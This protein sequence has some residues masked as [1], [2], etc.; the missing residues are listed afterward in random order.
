MKD[1]EKNVGLRGSENGKEAGSAVPAEE[2]V[3]ASG[4]GV[5]PPQL[6]SGGATRVADVAAGGHVR[7]ARQSGADSA[8]GAGTE[9]KKDSGVTFFAPKS[10][11]HEEAAGRT[12]RPGTAGTAAKE[13]DEALS[14]KDKL[15]SSL[16]PEAQGPVCG[17]HFLAPGTPA[18]SEQSAKTDSG[19]QILQSEAR[20]FAAGMSP[21][22]EGTVRRA[23][24]SSEAGTMAAE[25]S[26]KTPA[27]SGEV[28]ASRSSGISS[29]VPHEAADETARCARLSPDAAMLADAGTERTPRPGS[30]NIAARN[31]GQKDS[32]VLLKQDGVRSFALNGSSDPEGTIRRTWKSPD[33]GEQARA[34]SQN[35]H[36]QQSV[37]EV[38]TN[39]AK[40]GFGA[41]PAEFGARAFPPGTAAD[42]G[43]FRRNDPDPSETPGKTRPDMPQEPCMCSFSL[44]NADPEATVRR[45]FSG[46]EP[47]RDTNEDPEGTL[48]RRH[49]S[50]GDAGQNAN[51]G[52]E[53]AQA[54]SRFFPCRIQ[55]H[56]EQLEVV[57]CLGRGGEGELYL[58]R[59]GDTLYAAKILQQDSD[60]EILSA[61]SEAQERLRKHH[62]VPC[63]HVG[64]MRDIPGTAL[65]S[66][67]YVIH[68]FYA[69]GDL[70][71]L[72]NLRK[73]NP[74]IRYSGEKPFRPVSECYVSVS[75]DYAQ[76]NEEEFARLVS[77]MA[78]SLKALHEESFAAGTAGAV[79]RDI[80]PQN[81]FVGSDG[82]YALG[83]FGLISAMNTGLSMKFTQRI[84]LSHGYSPPEAYS[85]SAFK[86]TV[87]RKYDYFSLGMTLLHI[88]GGRPRYIIDDAL[89]R[90]DSR[91]VTL[92]DFYETI[93]LSAV[94]VPEELPRRIQNLIRGLL[95]ADPED[96]WG[97]REVSLWLAGENPVV[98]M[99]DR[100]S[101]PE[102][103]L[104]VDGKKESGAQN[105]AAAMV[106]DW[107][108]FSNL[109]SRG[110]LR[111]DWDSPD[112]TYQA[113]V[114]QA[115]EEAR[116][117]DPDI[118][119]QTLILTVD[120][121]IGHVFRGKRYESDEALGTAMLKGALTEEPTESEEYFNE[122][123]TKGALSNS[124][125]IAGGRRD[126]KVFRSIVQLEEAAKERPLAAM[127]AAGSI[128]AKKRIPPVQV[129]AGHK[130]LTFTEAADITRW[131]REELQSCADAYSERNIL[132]VKPPMIPG[133]WMCAQG[134]CLRQ[135]DGSILIDSAE[136]LEPFPVSGPLLGL[137]QFALHPDRDIP[138]LRMNERF[139]AM[140]CRG[141]YV[142]RF[143]SSPEEKAEKRSGFMPANL[144]NFLALFPDV[145]KNHG[146]DDVFL[147]ILKAHTDRLEYISGVRFP[148][149]VRR[150]VSDIDA[151]AGRIRDAANQF[152]RTRAFPD[153][154]ACIFASN[155]VR[156]TLV[157]LRT[158]NYAAAEKVL[159]LAP[160][161]M[162][163]SDPDF[164]DSFSRI[165]DEHT[166]FR[167]TLRELFSLSSQLAQFEEKMQR[168]AASDLSP[169]LLSDTMLFIRNYNQ[170]AKQPLELHLP[171]TTN[172]AE[173]FRQLQTQVQKIRTKLV[174][175][176]KTDEDGN[177]IQAG[178]T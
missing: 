52:T 170:S 124:W 149:T 49:E 83:D 134:E 167:G 112:I 154:A 162:S 69:K 133:K 45:T 99:K 136:I 89:A 3:R 9:E 105:V 25:E 48:R 169:Y 150:S 75:C 21:D 72:E 146:F 101:H 131:V 107:D 111:F 91:A 88:A 54:G 129:K 100:E 110:K 163:V 77:Q 56:M 12:G 96:R 61:M 59:S 33:A 29:C 128:L 44:E 97:E 15:R 35:L 84:G 94:S 109:L 65:D 8:L 74:S 34:G 87:T 14:P 139:F 43:T 153:F 37:Q 123:L 176:G 178:R 26:G 78:K 31:A 104:L 159:E 1:A 7:E 103:S 98:P 165:L 81:I 23:W 22:P 92:S 53:H 117:A 20:S 38:T 115:L 158:A 46:C 13:S 58:C 39:A 135:I 18:G 68:P 62:L 36:E 126:D 42:R 85:D 71:R 122:F 171:D 174:F 145:R 164:R 27:P 116:F 119:L 120:K 24:R 177:V 11:S 127:Y 152:R 118:G 132:P 82:E 102:I 173:Y 93:M 140:L 76:V 86:Q 17:V 19:A 67:R 60:Y 6:G 4:A 64:R 144:L 125:R 16:D 73:I 41:E 155:A 66:R 143:G 57:R 90:S 10:A 106:R 40:T 80:K 172:A 138:S 79:H 148:G 147:Q 156:E 141:G 28:P 175:M 160:R 108:V 50:R 166:A 2:K 51:S 63:I 113:A 161:V 121:K 142:A 114:E 5:R 137:V 70:A 168:R 32:E 95:L 151:A 157:K 30:G 55:G 47:A 130:E